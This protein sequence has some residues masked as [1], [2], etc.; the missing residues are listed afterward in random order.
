M[1][2]LLTWFYPSGGWLISDPT[3]EFSVYS[4]LI[5]AQRERAANP[6]EVGLPDKYLAGSEPATIADELPGAIPLCCSTTQRM[7][8]CP[9]PNARPISCNDRPAFQRDQMSVFCVAENPAEFLWVI[10][11]TFGEKICLR[12]CCP[13]LLIPPR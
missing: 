1:L 5:L 6:W 9:L 2:S 4:A 7:D 13:D 3:P 10:D 12:W 11:T 8:E